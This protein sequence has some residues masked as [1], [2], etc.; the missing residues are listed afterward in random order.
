MSFQ[1]LR[2]ME[3][4]QENIILILFYSLSNIICLPP[5]GIEMYI[6][7][8]SLKFIVLLQEKILKHIKYLWEEILENQQNLKEE[9]QITDM[10]VVSMR[11]S[12]LQNQFEG[13]M[14]NMHTWA[15]WA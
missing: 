10:W 14:F 6:C 12:F 5:S 7:F 8:S 13:D 1:E 3:G 15:W 9:N 4:K 11:V 2:V